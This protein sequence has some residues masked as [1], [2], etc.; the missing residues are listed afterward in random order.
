[1]WRSILLTCA[2]LCWAACCSASDGQPTPQPETPEEVARQ[3]PSN[4]DPFKKRLYGQIGSSWY[5]SSGVNKD[6]ITPGTIRVAF[7]VSAEGKIKQLR[8]LSNTSNK[9]MEQISLAAIRG[10]QIP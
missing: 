7:T 5:H 1:M 10:T 6:K 3:M 2:G 4:W 9:L 8:V